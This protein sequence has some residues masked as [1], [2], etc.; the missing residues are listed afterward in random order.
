MYCI[1]VN[2]K[3]IMILCLKKAYNDTDDVQELNNK[4]SSLG[5]T[6]RRS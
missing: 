4:L 6:L 3:H 2:I 5:S 1:L